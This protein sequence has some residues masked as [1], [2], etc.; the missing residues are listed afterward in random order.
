[1][2]LIDANKAFDMTK[3]NRIEARF[4][5]MQDYIE[6]FNRE[7]TRCTSKG[8][9]LCVISWS[10]LG[11]QAHPSETDFGNLAFFVEYLMDNYYEVEY[12]YHNPR[13]HDVSGIVVAWGPDA[14]NRINQFFS[15]TQGYFYRGEEVGVH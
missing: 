6:I 1:M 13:H 12:Y 4:S 11:V 2:E 14:S 5:A 9:D 8:A 7:V 10:M 15:E 3:E